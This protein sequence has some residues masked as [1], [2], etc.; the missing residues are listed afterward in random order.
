MS[1]FTIDQRTPLA[2]PQAERL[3][4]SAQKPKRKINHDRYKS[5]AFGETK[6]SRLADACDFIPAKTG[7]GHND[8]LDLSRV[9]PRKLARVVKAIEAR[10]YNAGTTSV[11]AIV[12]P[13]IFTLDR[14]T[15]NSRTNY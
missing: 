6:T 1:R 10:G 12:Q 3:P 2:S 11:R 7:V 15:G 8:A 13:R 9:S 4:A 14:A 5:P